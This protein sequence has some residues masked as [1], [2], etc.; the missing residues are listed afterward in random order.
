MNWIHLHSSGY[1]T[2]VAVVNAV[3]NIWVLLIEVKLLAKLSAAV[4]F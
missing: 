3:M 2:M 4:T 1:G